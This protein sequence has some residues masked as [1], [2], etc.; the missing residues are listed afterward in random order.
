M[1]TGGRATCAPAALVMRDDL[2]GE[3][4]GDLTLIKVILH[5][6]ER[7]RSRCKKREPHCVLKA[8]ANENTG[9]GGEA[10]GALS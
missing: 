2:P 4:L 8:T 1:K 7:D 6:Y 10:A 9:G 5:L 3:A